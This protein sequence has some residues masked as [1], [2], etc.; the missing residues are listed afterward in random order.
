MSV[1]AFVAAGSGPRSASALPGVNGQQ[2]AY[3]G[4]TQFGV[5]RS[6]SPESRVG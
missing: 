6:V 3:G 4:L 2:S 1:S 5:H